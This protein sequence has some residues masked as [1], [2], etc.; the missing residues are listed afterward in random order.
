MSSAQARA[1]A[2]ANEIKQAVKAVKA[3][4]A[5]V[6][7]LGEEMV[8]VLAQARAE[9]AIERTLIKYPS[10]LYQCAGCGQSVIFTEATRELP[11][12]DNC[13]GR[14]YNGPPPTVTAIKPPAPKRYAAG[15]YE[16]AACHAR[17]AFPEAVDTLTPCDFCGAAKL[18][19]VA[20]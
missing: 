20:L 11:A 6:K 12:C 18:R 9:A 8:R 2:L 19:A 16:C 1:K 14:D 4:E 7:Q 17:T 5:R 10:G 3:A 15:V 13:R